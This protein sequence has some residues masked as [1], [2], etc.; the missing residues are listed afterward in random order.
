[1]LKAI[2]STT[3]PI[4][5]PIT[6][7]FVAELLPVETTAP[8]AE[9]KKQIFSALMMQVIFVEVQF[10]KTRLNLYFLTV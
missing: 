10:I 6:K 3:K 1:M 8:V 4:G 5:K 9:T 2:I 7:G